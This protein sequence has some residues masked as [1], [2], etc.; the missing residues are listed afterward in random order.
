MV[1]NERDYEEKRNYIRM[2]MNASATL[3][4]KDGDAIDVTC[5]DLSATGMSIRANRAVSKGTSV[6]VNIQS[7]NE[8]FRSMDA[9]AVVLR[10]EPHDN[11]D[12]ELGLE[13][14]AIK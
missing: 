2:T 1:L 12:Y 13:I 5:I 4:I 9:D 14:E 11:G 8:Q 10:C 7:P 3:S 6:H